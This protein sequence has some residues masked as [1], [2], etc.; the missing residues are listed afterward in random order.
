[1]EPSLLSQ[2]DQPAT[3]LFGET[4]R[5]WDKEALLEELQNGFAKDVEIFK[6]EGFSPFWHQLDELL[7][8]KGRTIR[9]FDGENHWTGICQGISPD[10]RLKLE[11][12]NGELKLLASGDI[13][14]EK[15]IV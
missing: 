2:I 6:K 5:L 12:P 11:L 15:P 1:M 8:L 4:G 9:C 10:G 3:S 7:A 13:E 14:P